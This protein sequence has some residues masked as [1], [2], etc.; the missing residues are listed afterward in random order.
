MKIIYKKILSCPLFE[1]IKYEEL[2]QLLQ[3]IKA[4]YHSYSKNDIIFMQDD[5]INEIGI[6]LS[7]NIDIAKEDYVGNKV[8]I[9]RLESSDLFA[10]VFVCS[11]K[12]ISPVTVSSHGDSEI[13]F[14]DFNQLIGICEHSC[15]F[16]KKLISNMMTILAN[17]TLV[18][19]EKME[20]LTKKTIEQKLSIY[21]VN[22]IRKNANLSF[23]IP[24]KRYE[25][26]EYLHSNRSALSRVLSLL[27]KKG[28]LVY[29]K[30]TFTIISPKKL[31]KLYLEN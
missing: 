5:V 1:G 6:I 19:N 14:I 26:A 22:Q 2:P 21:L 12:N 3:C 13:M 24:F 25:L 9:S 31:Y 27:Q 10:E 16:H 30:N 18:M 11:G 29:K 15:T 4:N 17:K 20:Y 7:G 8:I 23:T 28:I